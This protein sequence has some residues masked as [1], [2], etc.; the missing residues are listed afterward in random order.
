MQTIT[1]K[2]KDGQPKEYTLVVLRI[3]GWDDKGRPSQA[4]IGYDDTTFDLT[5]DSVSREFAT[6][7]IPSKVIEPKVVTKQ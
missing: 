6:A 3:T 5:D 1:I 7:F 4:I 2:T